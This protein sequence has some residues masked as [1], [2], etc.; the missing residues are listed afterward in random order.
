MP[1]KGVM[2][3]LGS[4]QGVLRELK[5]GVQIRHTAVVPTIPGAGTLMADA[6]QLPVHRHLER[7]GSVPGGQEGGRADWWGVSGSVLGSWG[8]LKLQGVHILA[9]FPAHLQGVGDH[10]WLVMQ[11]KEIVMLLMVLMVTKVTLVVLTMELMVGM[12]TVVVMVTLVVL[13]MMVLM[14]GMVTWW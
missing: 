1:G 4:V 3:V 6:C 2:S 11:E 9:S 13:T 10:C 14:V 7:A 12:V 5:N 8:L